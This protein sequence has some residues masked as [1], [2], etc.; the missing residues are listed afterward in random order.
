MT[1][2]GLHE[3]YDGPAADSGPALRER[4]EAVLRKNVVSSA[5]QAAVLS[6]G[7]AAELLHELRVH[8]IELEM[9]NEELRA[10]SLRLAAER[11]RYFE[12]YDRAPAGYVTV[13]ESGLILDA[14]LT[15][16]T[17]LGVTRRSLPTRPLSS[18]IL[19]EDADEFYLSRMRCMATGEAQTWDLR[20]V[21]G[22]GMPVW[23]QLAA[24]AVS[25]EADHLE[26]EV[27]IVV[28][29]ISALRRAEAERER[30]AGENRRME[31]AH[32]L[33]RMAAGI[34]HHF[35]NQ[36]TAVIGH[37]DVSMHQLSRKADPSASMIRAAQAARKAAEVSSLLLTYL[38]RTHGTRELLDL[39][40]A[41]RRELSE[42]RARMP[43]RVA[44]EAHWPAHGPGIVGNAHD[45]QQALAN[46]LSNSWETRGDGPIVIRVR[47]IRQ[48]AAATIPTRH[49]FPT[50][51]QA[52]SDDYACLEVEDDGCGIA[53]MDIE[54]I[55]DPFFSSKFTGRGL[56]LPVVLGIVRGH[57][58]VLTVESELGRGTV[59]RI[60]LP[61]PSI[62]SLTLG[63]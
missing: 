29:D 50:D 63:A 31:K 53:A 24:T 33:N 26:L 44:L 8:Q 3:D 35:N 27:R 22:D 47:V 28:S 7:G 21:K 5:E 45:L 60:F 43:S 37:L 4:A 57:D 12:L 17:L 20:I 14:N 52:E 30:L 55:F 32:S 42:L 10:S 15:L 36:L 1:T 19:A 41:C 9:Q 2:R 56:G 59:F 23:V 25:R 48:V 62:A 11:A 58:G 40:E 6:P 34:A 38:V 46:L 51:W 49:R 18:F 61:L 16:A 39:S 13:D 54:R